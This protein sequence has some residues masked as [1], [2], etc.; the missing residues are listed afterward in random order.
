MPSKVQTKLYLIPGTMCNDKLWSELL[1]YLHNSIELIYLAIPPEKNVD[2]LA[3]YYH[4]LLASDKVN[5]IGFSLGGYIASYFAIKYPERV[6]KLFVIS[7]SPTRLP[8]DEVKQRTDILNLVQTYGYQGVSRDRIT[9][10]LDPSNQRSRLIELIS[11]MDKEL[12]EEQFISQY[13]YTSGRADLAKALGHLSLPAYFYYSEGDRLVNSAWF[14]KLKDSNSK[15]SVISTS[16]AGHM[17]P[18]ENL[19]NWPIT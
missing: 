17:L 3:E 16:G 15:V 13:Q 11:S 2:E 4:D 18:L 14:N 19:K 10:L 5:L 9:H 6:E 7:N 8:A 12:G 1:P